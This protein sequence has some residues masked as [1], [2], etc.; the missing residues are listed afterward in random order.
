MRETDFFLLFFWYWAPIFRKSSAFD[1]KTEDL[2]GACK[3]C[4]NAEVSRS[5]YFLRLL[6]IFKKRNLREI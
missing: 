1:P 5:P 2:R 6:D 4:A 3:K